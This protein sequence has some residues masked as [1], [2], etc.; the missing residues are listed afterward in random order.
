M[1]TT[2]PNALQNLSQQGPTVGIVDLCWQTSL[3]TPA[4]AQGSNV[5]IFGCAEMPLT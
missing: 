4:Q 5:P 1:A 2:Y 3:V